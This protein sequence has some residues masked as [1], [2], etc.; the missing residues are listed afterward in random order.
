MGGREAISAMKL[1]RLV[2]VF[3]WLAFPGGPAQAHAIVLSSAPRPGQAVSGE[4]LSIEIRFNS[5]IDAERSQLK[6]FRIDGDAATLPATDI[7]SPDTLRAKATGLE[8]GAYRLHWQTLS[9]DGHI[10]QGDIPF[11]VVR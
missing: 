2:P 3:L 9:P 5:R 6:L 10:T 8:P 4:E 7:T 11:S 1:L